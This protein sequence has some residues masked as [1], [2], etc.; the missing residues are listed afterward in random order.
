MMIARWYYPE[1]S[2]PRC[3]E[4]LRSDG[5]EGCF[6][7]RDSRK[8][9]F[10][11]LSLFTKSITWWVPTPRYLTC[12]WRHTCVDGSWQRSGYT[13]AVCWCSLLLV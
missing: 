9:G 7:V 3:E 1:T 10:Y 11:T 5:N 8:A 2:V 12:L 6:L 13:T 4:I